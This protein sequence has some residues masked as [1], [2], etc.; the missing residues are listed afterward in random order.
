MPCDTDSDQANLEVY[1]DVLSKISHVCSNYI[2]VY[3]TIIAGDLNS[4]MTRLNSLHIIALAEYREN[5]G[6]LLCSGYTDDEVL[7]TYINEFTGSRSKLDQF[8]YLEI[9]QVTFVVITP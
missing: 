7:F 9:Y 4:E 2:D 1:I 5:E 3:H 8:S 6:L